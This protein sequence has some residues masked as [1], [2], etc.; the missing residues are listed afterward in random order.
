MRSTQTVADYHT[1][2]THSTGGPRRILYDVFGL[3]AHRG[4]RVL[5][6][7]DQQCVAE[8]E[9]VR[10]HKEQRLRG[11]QRGLGFHPE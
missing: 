6:R 5:A 7:G 10:N 4:A 2:G 11:G 8:L 1:V 3:V 9:A